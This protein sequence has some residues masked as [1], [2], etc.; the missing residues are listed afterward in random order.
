MNMAFEGCT[1]LKSV[2]F[3]DGVTA[4]GWR[5][6][7]GCS[8][9]ESVEFNDKMTWF[10]ACAFDGCSSLKSLT[11]PSSLELLSDDAFRGC[12]GLTSVAFLA[13]DVEIFDRYGSYTPFS[14][15]TGIKSVTL[16]Q[17]AAAKFRNLF[18]ASAKSVTDVK[19]V[20]GATNVAG[21]AFN[22]CTG[23]FSL[24]SATE[25]GAKQKEITGYKAYGVLLLARDPYAPLDEGVIAPGF[26]TKK[27]KSTY[28]DE[29]GKKKT[30]TWP[31]SAPFNVVAE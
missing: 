23:G 28:L 29:K 2:K 27:V 12:T 26:A 3:K 10:A 5:A 25:D 16:S 8:N 15:C 9:L 1:S 18:S 17:F 31:F 24:W 14:G 11:I 30:V 21:G 19:I 13:E 22:G 7:Y 4:V 6:F 20:D